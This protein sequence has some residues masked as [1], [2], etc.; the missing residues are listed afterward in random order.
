MIRSRRVRPLVLVAA[1]AL[2][3]TQANRDRAVLAGP[4][5][6]TEEA[7]LPLVREPEPIQAGRAPETEGVYN[8]GTD[9]LHYDVELAISSG[10]PEIHGE[11]TL[12]LTTES[13]QA[14]L[15]LTGLAVSEVRVNGRRVRFS[16][17]N[18]KLG[19]PVPGTRAPAEVL[20]RYHGTPD[21]GLIHGT[22]VHGTP[23]VF[24]DNWP[25]RARF[26]LPSVDHPSDKA[27]IRFR[28]H[29]PSQWQVIA[30]GRLEDGPSETPTG[31]LGELGL[32]DPAGDYATWVWHSEVPIP[33]YTMVIGATEF[34]RVVLGEAACGKAPA[35]PTTGGC[36]EVGHWV[37][38]PDVA[39]AATVFG[40][41]AEM[42]DFFTDRVGPYP[43]EKLVN[44]QSSTRFGGMENASA[45]FYAERLLADGT[46]IEGTVSHEIAHQWFG[47]SV[48]ER[49]WSHLWL[50]EGF[51]T[52]FGSLFFEH[53]DGPERF[54]ELLANIRSGYL[55]S[56]TTGVP[57]VQENEDL[58]QLLNA[59]N[60]QK[61]GMVLHM[62]R[63]VLGDSAF[64]GGV[65]TYYDSFQN[66]TALTD[67]LQKAL[68][69]ASGKELGWF[70]DQWLRQ[71]GHPVFEVEWS[72]AD[73]AVE[74]VIRQVQDASWPAFNMPAQ[75]EVRDARGSTRHE[76]MIE[77]R[78]TRVE[79]PATARPSDVVLD[80]DGWILKEVR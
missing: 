66:G 13:T 18:G 4:P 40:R 67:D 37:F 49:D 39:H 10:S 65:R 63:G 31:R 52:Y 60:Y 80:P 14:V 55:S 69:L 78:T 70:F 48:T 23:S 27:T 33:S 29:A 21:D 64:F 74:L 11:A 3:C 44:V 38:P 71:P 42:V 57:I 30:N 12:T 43:Y 2:G 24:A 56:Q 26:W 1:L 22:T 32:S 35:A 73:S 36:V 77:G 79:L 9:V 17:R 75:V 62:L 76:V 61:G 8:A 15:D 20:I 51:A 45:I 28:V 72:Y 54:Q 41:S 7:S 50:S 16:Y 25:N 68:E 46:D 58:F 47:D 5:P 59:N 53:A 34:E 6:S 19:I